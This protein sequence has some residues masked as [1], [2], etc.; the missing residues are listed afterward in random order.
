[1]E[2]SVAN[3]PPYLS[4]NIR[5]IFKA[6]LSYPDPILALVRTYQFEASTKLTACQYL[7]GGMDVL[8][9]IKPGDVIIRITIEER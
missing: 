3:Y 1:M 6:S 5:W 8:Q 9:R 4:L 2:P 7:A